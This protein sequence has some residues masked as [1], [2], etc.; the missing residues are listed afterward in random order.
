MGHRT[1][2]NRSSERSVSAANC[3][4]CHS[5]SPSKCGG[6]GLPV[7]QRPRALSAGTG[8]RRLRRHRGDWIPVRAMLHMARAL[9]GY[10]EST[11]PPRQSGS[12]PGCCRVVREVSEGSRRLSAVSG[13]APIAAESATWRTVPRGAS[14]RPLRYDRGVA[15]GSRHSATGPGFPDRRP[16][17]PSARP[18]CRTTGFPDNGR[19]AAVD[20]E[21]LR[22]AQN[23]PWTSGLAPARPSHVTWDGT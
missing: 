20:A 12:S 22:R 23:V 16:G 3:P 17:C 13:S 7:R 9:T 1:S 2:F 8:V 18:A 11:S 19:S 6:C 4:R 15:L 21:L 10:R 5:R 14:P